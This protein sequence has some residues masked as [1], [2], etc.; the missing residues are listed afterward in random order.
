MLQEIYKLP[1]GDTLLPEQEAWV[2]QKMRKL[3]RYAKLEPHI[4]Y[5]TLDKYGKHTLILCWKLTKPKPIPLPKNQLASNQSAKTKAL[6]RLRKVIEPQ[7]KPLRKMGLHVDHKKPFSLIAEE[8]FKSKKLS[9]SKLRSYH[10]PDFYAYHLE[11]ATYQYLTPQE[12]LSKGAKY[13]ETD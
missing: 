3:T 7:I 4:D 1:L 5:F 11:H 13:D 6:K 2:R 8:W 12:N 10:Y 9:Y